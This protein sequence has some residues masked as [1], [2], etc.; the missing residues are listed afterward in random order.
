MSKKNLQYVF[1]AGI[2]C[3]TLTI[4]A[5]ALSLMVASP[6]AAGC[7]ILGLEVCPP[8]PVSTYYTARLVGMG[9]LCLDPVD[10]ARRGRGNVIQL[11]NCTPEDTQDWI[12]PKNGVGPIYHKRTGLC[13]DAKDYGKQGAGT[14]IQLW[15][16]TKE[17]SQVWKR[18]GK[19]IL[20]GGG[21]N[22]CLDPKDYGR[23]GRGTPIQ[24]WNCNGDVA[25]DWETR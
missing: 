3:L 11:W 12:I 22:L 24:L 8:R 5:S 4:G 13:L 1:S 9:G 17:P 6:A 2:A 18:V 7:G 10:Y 15:D 16:C 20:W 21:Q 25:Q 14:P 23:Q 19:K